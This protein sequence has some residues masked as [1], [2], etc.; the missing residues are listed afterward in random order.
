MTQ[1]SKLDGFV[2]ENPDCQI[3]FRKSYYHAKGRFCSHA[4]YM[5][6]RIV[7]VD[8]EKAITLYESGLTAQK[9]ADTLGV[10]IGV[11]HSRFRSAGYHRRKLRRDQRAENNPNWR[12][13]RRISNGYVKVLTPDHPRADSSGYVFEH[14]IVA[15]KMIGRFLVWKGLRHPESEVVH[16][17]DHDKKNNHPDNLQVMTSLEHRQHHLERRSNPKTRNFTVTVPF[18]VYERLQQVATARGD[19]L[20]GVASDFIREGVTATET[21]QRAY[22]RKVA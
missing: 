22:A 19:S 20:S 3:E 13:G 4:C 1:K 8:V 10:P 6:V 5:A 11:I 12:D 2:C 17:K 7:K 9:V 18:A 16:H 15:E 14:I 21:H